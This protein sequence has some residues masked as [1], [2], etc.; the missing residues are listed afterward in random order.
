MTIGV[1]FGV[2]S[3]KIDD[4]EVKVGVWCVCIV[5]ACTILIAF[6]IIV[7]KGKFLGLERA[8]RVFRCA[9]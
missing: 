8:S 2:K 6:L 4:F 5:F 7:M 3:V 9:K 1:D